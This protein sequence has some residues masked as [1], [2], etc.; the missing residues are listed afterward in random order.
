MHDPNWLIF[1]VILRES[2]DV[3]LINPSSGGQF[4]Q[5]LHGGG[6]GGGG[7]HFDEVLEVRFS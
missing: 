6:G 5:R 1:R 3:S 7:G 4:S 2:I